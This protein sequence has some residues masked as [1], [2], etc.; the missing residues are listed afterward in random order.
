MRRALLHLSLLT[1][2][3]PGV[4][5][6]EG[7][8]HVDAAASVAQTLNGNRPQRLPDGS[9][10]LPKVAQRRLAVRTVLAAVADH[11][12]TIEL[13]GHVVMDPSAGGKVQALVAGRVE[14]GPRGLPLPGQAVRQGELLAYVRPVLGA[15][16]R[17]GQLAQLAELRSARQLAEKN[18]ARLRELEGSVPRRDIDAA[19]AELESLAGRLQ[20]V[21]AGVEGRDALRAPVSGVVAS[22]AVVAGQVVDAKEVLF[23]VVDPARLLVEAQ[24]FDASLV[25]QLTDAS[26][27]GSDTRLRY[28]GGSRALRDGALPL[29]FRLES[30]SATLA[31]GQPVKLLARSRTTRKGVALPTLAVVRNPANEAIVWLHAAA[32]RFMPV[33]VKVLP[34]DSA[35]VL[36][37]GVSAGARVVTGGATLINQIR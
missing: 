28:L 8:D 1:L 33:P 35:T 32:E 24:A 15:A 23:E 5:A 13:N 6:H 4:L 16:E 14:P 17:S 7:H 36:V 2:I 9:V 10:F 21:S 26:L 27:A 19:E 37:Q 29:L 30:S 22:V 20:A 25:D 12:Q 3:P 31:L 34:L 11:P 18:L